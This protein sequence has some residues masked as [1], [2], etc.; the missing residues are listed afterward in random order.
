MSFVTNHLGYAASCIKSALGFCTKAAA[1]TIASC[2]LKVMVSKIGLS[3]PIT[4]IARK[5]Q[6]AAVPLKCADQLIRKM[7]GHVA[8]PIYYTATRP[9]PSLNGEDCYSTGVFPR[10]YKCKLFNDSVLAGISEE[11][12]LRGLLQKQILPWIAHQLPGTLGNLLN[13]KIARIALASLIFAGGHGN[14]DVSFQFVS[15]V[16]YGTVAEVSGSVK[17]PMLAH[18]MNNSLIVFLYTKI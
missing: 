16:V 5:L 14:D 6:F 2:S 18:I 13:H 8:P 12:L 1:L 17:I 4:A 9:F 15:G 3:A 11:L 7:I 10:R